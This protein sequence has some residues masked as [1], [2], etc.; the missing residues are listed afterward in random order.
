MVDHQVIFADPGSEW[1]APRFA[2]TVEP[3]ARLAAAFGDRVILT[4]WVP[5]AAKTGSWGP[6]FERWPFADRPAT[7]PVYDLV[8]SAVALGA[9]HTVTEA[10]FGK[11]GEQLQAITGPAPHL[12]LVGVATDC[13]V[14]ATALPAADAGATVTV[15]SDA[16][17]ASTDEGQ[18]RALE[19]MAGFGPQIVVR[20]ADEVLASR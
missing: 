18:V 1:A 2:E 12:V 9:R 4:R 13:C 17:A 11:W 10:T 7:D 8:D 15:V 16:S 5:P 6:Y 3:V 19:L 20:T 14:V